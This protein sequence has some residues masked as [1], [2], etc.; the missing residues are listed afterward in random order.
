MRNNIPVTDCRILLKPGE[1]LVTKTDLQGRITYV[2]PAF[3]EISGFSE[4]ELVGENHNVVRHPDMPEAVFKDLWETLSLGRPW[5]GV[6]KNRCK[7]GDYYWVTANVTPLMKNG[8]LAEYMSVRT[9]PSEQQV[10]MTK[11]LY[12]QLKSNDVILPGP[13]S[14]VSNNYQAQINQWLVSS[15]GASVI[16]GVPLYFTSIS[17]LSVIGPLVGMGI[18]AFGANRVVKQTILS[19][20]NHSI[21]ELQKI[22]EGDYTRDISVTQQGESGKLLRMVKSIQI[23]LGFEVNDAKQMAQ[24][25]E[26]IKVA[27]DNVTSCVMMADNNGYIIYVNDSINKMFTAAESDIK[28]FLPDF[29]VNQLIGMKIENFYK[30]PAEQQQLIESLEKPF[31]TQLIIGT[32]HFNLSASPVIDDNKKRLGA[33]LEWNDVTQQLAAEADV[34]KLIKDAAVGILDSRLNAKEYSGFT[35]NVARGMNKML[36]SIVEPIEEVQRVVADL[37]N[38]KLNSRMKGNFKGAFN[39]LDNSLQIA[40]KKIEDTVGEIRT[41]SGTIASGAEEISKGNNTLSTRTESQATSLEETAASMEQMTATVKQNA[42]N[43]LQASK[44][45]ENAKDLAENGGEISEKVVRSMSEISRSSKKISEIITVIDEI[46]FQTN[47]LA[48]NAAVE[49]ARAGDQGRGFAVVAA[50]VRNLAQRSASAAKEIKGLISDSV[51]KVEEGGRFVDESGKALIEIVSAIH[52]V[53]SI[54]NGISLASTEQATGI[55]Q[56]NIAITNMDKSTQQ[57]A[58]LVEEVAAAS[59]SMEEQAVQ[60]RQLMRFF[61][62]DRNDEQPSDAARPTMVSPSKSKYQNNHIDGI[63]WEEF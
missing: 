47:L 9:N 10:E 48:L 55:N 36:D 56:V 7:N 33:V 54:V 20:I 61:S 60:L 13:S 27:L 21:N 11:R 38:G 30:D 31:N 41:N 44:L 18:L 57:N 22:T 24:R 3:I 53:S 34:E 58:E 35:G 37:E 39:E 19:G 2:N 14:V 40:M 12:E 1:D 5:V 59:E 4:K 49:A 50:E 51:D 28:Q 26:R 6:I 45:A 29:N 8:R 17:A 16:I 46:A 15:I 62:I 43:A 25:A 32:Q 63:E 42:D 23:K 52:E